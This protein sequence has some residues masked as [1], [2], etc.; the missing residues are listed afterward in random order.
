MSCAQFICGIFSWKTVTKVILYLYICCLVDGIL[1][2]NCYQVAEAPHHGCSEQQQQI[3]VCD[4]FGA[5]GV[6]VCM[7]QS[8][9]A[10]RHG[11]CD[12]CRKQYNTVLTGE[13]CSLPPLYIYIY[14]IYTETKQTNKQK[15]TLNMNKN[16]CIGLTC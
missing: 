10:T 12:M 3:I 8:T 1:L 4:N 7:A 6:V 5:V 9:I 15:S 11:M 16:V 2:Y 13:I 14:N